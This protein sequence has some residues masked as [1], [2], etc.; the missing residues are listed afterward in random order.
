MKSNKVLLSFDVEEFDLPKERGKDILLAEGVKVSS[1]GLKKIIN[2]LDERKVKA[3]FFITGNFAKMRPE[4]VLELKNK[5]HEIACHGVDHF[6]PAESDVKESKKIVEEVIGVKVKGYRQPR[7]FKINYDELQRYGYKYD[8]SVNPA[9]IP[10]RYNNFK[11]PRKVYKRKGIVELPVSAAT[12]VRIP[13]F[14]LALHLFP[15]RLYLSLT[16]S[17]LKKQQYFATYFHPWEFAD[18]KRYEVVSWYIM[19]NSGEKL[20]LRLSWLIDKLD[21]D[22]YEFLTYSEYLGV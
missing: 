15:K 5:G 4:L 14:W 12:S 10:G 2:I 1:E 8:S 16:R 20:A 17:V 9:F 7:M 6:K 13:L 19:M 22:G 18:L 3:T 11:T 21:Q